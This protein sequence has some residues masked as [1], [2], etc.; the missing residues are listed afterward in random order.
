MSFSHRIRNYYEQMVAEEILRQFEKLGRDKDG[1]VMADIACVAL[2]RL[3]PRYI[4]YEVDMAFYMSPDEL[5][6]MKNNIVQTVSAAIDFVG[7]HT[8]EDDS[9]DDIV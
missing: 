4:R 8:R 2:N 3:P 5:V 9:D 7:Q 6:S 1:G